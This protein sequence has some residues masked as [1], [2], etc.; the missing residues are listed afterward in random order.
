[1]FRKI[2]LALVIGS[3]M[4]GTAFAGMKEMKEAYASKD[5]VTCISE[6]GKVIA[7]VNA[8][9]QDKRSA[10]YMI[11]LSCYRQE[12]YS[13]A[14]TE[15]QKVFDYPYDNRRYA[16]AQFYIGVCEDAEGN[17]VEAQEAFCKVCINYNVEKLGKVAVDA[18]GNERQSFLGR[19]FIRIQQRVVG[20]QKY[21][22]VL[23]ALIKI[24]NTARTARLLGL[25]GSQMAKP[26]LAKYFK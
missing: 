21:V 11:G 26:D 1:M 12:K 9:I 14:K 6:A 10:Q 3:F 20:D 15:F 16:G 22:E 23:S 25:V 19:V 2:L 17:K 18:E 8:S 4:V 7:D 13:E 24:P 5:Y